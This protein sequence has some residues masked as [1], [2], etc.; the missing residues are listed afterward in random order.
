MAVLK[1]VE[2]SK[3]VTQTALYSLFDTYYRPIF[4][5][6]YAQIQDRHSA[7]DLV[8][9]TWIQASKSL[10]RELSMSRLLDGFLA[11]PATCAE[12]IIVVKGGSS[13]QK[14]SWKL[15]LNTDKK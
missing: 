3:I 13:L 4:A 6:V 8:Q 14:E 12:I 5:F 11:S 15:A 7:E 1:M 9:E 2:D 10:K